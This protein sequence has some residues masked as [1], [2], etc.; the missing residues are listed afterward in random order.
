MS[1]L[2]SS[3]E[4]DSVSSVRALNIR[5]QSI[6]IIC[7]CGC[8]A[9]STG[10]MMGLMAARIFDSGIEFCWTPPGPSWFYRL[11]IKILAWQARRKG[12]KGLLVMFES[13]D[14][15]RFQCAPVQLAPTNTGFETVGYCETREIHSAN[16][17]HSQSTNQSGDQKQES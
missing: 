4:K 15:R 16:G 9:L 2:P 12:L 10:V 7:P 1:A 8:G 6:T 13:I 3:A 11:S 14:G 17:P 5:V